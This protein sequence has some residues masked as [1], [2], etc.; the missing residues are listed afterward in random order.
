MATPSTLAAGATLSY[1]PFGLRL[2]LL[3]QARPARALR[4]AAVG[5]RARPGQAATPTGSLL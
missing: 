4:A 5:P 3:D 2:S 1:W